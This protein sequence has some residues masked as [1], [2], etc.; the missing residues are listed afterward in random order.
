MN[1]IK[2][3]PFTE[4][5]A[6]KEKQSTNKKLDIIINAPITLDNYCEALLERILTLTYSDYLHFLK[7]QTAQIQSPIIWLEE[8]E[9]FLCCNEELFI[10]KK[11]VT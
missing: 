10:E 9:Q 6:V 4:Y 8:L 3:A 7:H 5:V 1:R 11:N 2:I